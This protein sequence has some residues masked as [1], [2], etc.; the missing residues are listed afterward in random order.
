MTLIEARSGPPPDA[1]VAFLDV[2]DPALRGNSGHVRAAQ[3]SNWYARSALGIVVLRYQEA[4][5]LLADRRL[6]HGTTGWL[7]TQGVN[8]GP[9]SD[10]WRMIMPN[11]EGAS[12]A[13]LRRLVSKAFN[14]R[15]VQALRPAM[16]AAAHDLVD[17]FAPRGECDF[18]EA[19]ADPYPL[20]VICALLGVPAQDHPQLRRWSADLMLVIGFRVAEEL[21]RIE[22]AL[23]GVLSYLDD[24]IAERRKVRGT[25]LVSLL[26]SVEEAGERLT[27]DE[28]R[29]LLATLI[30][31]GHDSTSCQLAAGMATLLD[32]PDQ[33]T[34]LTA[35]PTLA[36]A[37]VE[38]VTRANPAAP[39]AYRTAAEDFEFQGLRIAAGD[40]VL[41][42]TA[43]ANS[44]P[45]VIDPA[46]FDI[47]AVRP[48][49]LTLGGGMHYC[50]GAALAR[51][52]M[53]EA[54]TILAAR[55]G[56]PRLAGPVSWRPFLGVFG[57]VALPIR[58]TTR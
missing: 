44:D 13:R 23:Q 51:M 28:L 32:H 15:S 3:A 12:H 18:V 56:E 34:H 35:D 17:G 30:F 31:A 49:S 55:L 5:V 46:G 27:A 26:I 21:G 7:A 16:R 39:F 50:L 22:A 48:A 6:L 11:V 2:H 33:W 42:F 25:D 1:E 53:Q 20:R 8:A 52:Q 57:P 47:T 38:E 58:F 24:L 54:F 41:I 4:Q 19:F 40:F 43:A 45:E 14:P 9:L 29:A 37:A 36:A 10:W